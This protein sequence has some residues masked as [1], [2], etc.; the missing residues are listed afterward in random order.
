[1]RSMPSRIQLSPNSTSSSGDSTK[2]CWA[3]LIIE[4]K[5]GYC[6]CRSSGKRNALTAKVDAEGHEPAIFAGMSEYLGRVREI[7]FEEYADY[8]APSHKALEGAGYTVFATEERLNG[9]QLRPAKNG[10]RVRRPYDIV[11]SYVATLDATRLKR[12][13]GPRKWYSLSG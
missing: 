2:A 12:I 1:M 3:L 4:A 10:A 7:I 13:L 6:R 5:V 9:P 11:P 8:P